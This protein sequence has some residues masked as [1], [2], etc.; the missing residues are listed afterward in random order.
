M[1]SL[2]RTVKDSKAFQL[3]SFAGYTVV[4]SIAC[5]AT[6]LAPRRVFFMPMGSGNKAI[7]LRH[8][9][10]SDNWRFRAVAP[11]AYRNEEDAF[12]R[13]SVGRLTRF[14]VENVANKSRLVLV[15]WGYADR[16]RMDL[17]CR[18]LGCEARYLEAGLFGFGEEQKHDLVSYVCDAQSPYFDGRAPTDLEDLLNNVEPGAWRN[19]PELVALHGALVASDRQKYPDMASNEVVDLGADDLLIV[20][21]VAGDA[22]WRETVT[23]V[24][25]NVDL[26]LKARADYGAGRVCYYKPHPYNGSNK[27]DIEAI[28]RAAPDVIVIQNKVRMRALLANRPLVAVNTS[29][30]GAEALLS[31]CRVACYGAS[32][33]AGWGATE[34]KFPQ[35]ERRSTRLSAEDVFLAIYLKYCRYFRRD[36]LKTATAADLVAALTP[37]SDHR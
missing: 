2:A 33:Y 10:G 31:G 26:V 25:N 20:G 6:R 7:V 21:Q 3:A 5:L 16:R 23:T 1:R 18:S 37:A 15:I 12:L 19:D 4:L 24:S 28:R 36:T 34:D 8:V 32:C 35:I 27:R 13:K 17:D 14:M 9:A 30:A 22:A 11:K 29:G